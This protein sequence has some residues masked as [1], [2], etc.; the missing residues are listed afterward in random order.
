MS[1]LRQRNPGKDANLL[2]STRRFA[3]FLLFCNR[4]ANDVATPGTLNIEEIVWVCAAWTTSPQTMSIKRVRF[5]I[6]WSHAGRGTENKNTTYRSI[7]VDR[8]SIAAI[9]MPHTVCILLRVKGARRSAG[10]VMG[11]KFRNKPGDSHTSYL[12]SRSS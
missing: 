6:N 9:K 11:L 3:F 7:Q 4:L 5:A 10:G 12:Y 1:S 2:P 8:W